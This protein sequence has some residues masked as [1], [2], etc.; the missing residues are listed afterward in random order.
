VERGYTVATWNGVGFD[1]DILAE[2]SGMLTQ[3]RRLALD[4]VDP[5]FH[6]LCELGFGVSLQAAARGMKL[7]GKPEGMNGA[8]APV[9]WAEGRREV[10]L[11]YVAQDARTTAKLAREC[12]A[13]GTFR[14]IT[15]R[16]V[17]RT[18]ELPKG[19]L[20]VEEAE[21]LPEPD[22]SWMAEPWARA[23]F[24]AWLR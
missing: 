9:L 17:L 4:H 12:E 8:M 3:C 1:F 7:A 23:E 18:M 16:R 15:R 2:E 22:T 11:D 21:R 24:T 14:W 6:I 10:V 20:T 19:W 13:R 5:M